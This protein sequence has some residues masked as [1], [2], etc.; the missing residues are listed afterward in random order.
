[1]P[2]LDFEKDFRRRLN[3]REIKPSSESWKNLNGRLEKEKKTKNPFFRLGIA[4]AISGIIILSFALDQDQISTEKP[5]VVENSVEANPENEEKMIGKEQPQIVSVGVD[6]KNDQ[7]EEKPVI[8]TQKVKISDKIQGKKEEAVLADNS[9][10]D[11]QKKISQKPVLEDEKFLSTFRSA[12]EFA[13]TKNEDLKVTNAEIDALLAEAALSLSEEENSG[14]AENYKP[15]DLL[16]EVEME[17]EKS[18]RQKVFEL[19]KEGFSEAKTAV[20]NRN[21]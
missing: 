3:D 19:M 4:A 21:F 14:I 17:L 18:F 11:L 9:H 20:A 12:G 15:E 16:F 8:T 10:I 13:G 7:P 6:L 5:V 2:P 1:M